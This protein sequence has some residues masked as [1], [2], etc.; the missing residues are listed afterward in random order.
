MLNSIQSIWRFVS[1]Q[2]KRLSFFQLFF[3]SFV[4]VVEIINIAI[5]SSFLNNIENTNGVL[6][7][8]ILKSFSTTQLGIACIVSA[9]IVM[10]FTSLNTLSIS[11]LG[12]SIGIEITNKTFKKQILSD[13]EIQND[14][15]LADKISNYTFARSILGGIFLPLFEAFSSLIS[16]LALLYSI[17]LFGGLYAS[18]MILF[19]GISYLIISLFCSKKL[20]KINKRIITLNQQNYSCLNDSFSNT[21]INYSSNIYQNNYINFKEI[22]KELQNYAADFIIIAGLPR[23]LIEGLGILL[24]TVIGLILIFTKNENSLSIV[25]VLALGLQRLLPRANL[26]YRSISAIRSCKS[27]L[28][29]V[30][31]T[32]SIKQDPVLEH[33]KTKKYKNIKLTNSS[34]STNQLKYKFKNG[35]IIKYEDF[36]INKG[37]LVGLV[38][39]SGSG[40]STLI[41]L[42]AGFRKPSSG[43]IMVDGIPLWGKGSLHRRAI[44]RSTLGIVEQEPYMFKDSVLSNIILSKNVTL[45]ELELYKLKKCLEVSC[46]DKFFSFKEILKGDKLMLKEFGKELSGGMK[47]RLGLCRALYKSQSWLFIDEGTSSI[48]LETERLIIEG[49]KSEFNSYGIVASAHRESMIRKLKKIIKL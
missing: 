36:S 3:S 33:L 13:W 6:E 10:I 18:I 46:V 15:D 35:L 14:I 5:L 7:L 41:D 48:D 25:G 40:K 45:S 37:E 12:A 8:N 27:Q 21:R 9:I 28:E 44:W 23:T 32:L 34:L 31:E 4:S 1:P 19:I 49:L 20:N 22:N 38:G 42:L 24:A 2:K 43:N 29:K 17:I 39:Q 30:I 26:F 47:Q 11:K 16:S